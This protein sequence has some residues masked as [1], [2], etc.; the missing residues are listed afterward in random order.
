MVKAVILA[1]GYGTRLTRDIEADTTGVYAHLVGVPK[2]LLPIGT[3]GLCMAYCVC[4]RLGH[5]DLAG[6]VPL[7]T[8]WMNDIAKIPDIDGICVVVRDTTQLA[9][10]LISPFTNGPC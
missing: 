10:A 9:T 6:G 2:P 1:A 4:F 5:S 8:R 3:R 7:C